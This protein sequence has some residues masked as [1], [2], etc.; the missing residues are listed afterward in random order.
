MLTSWR[1]KRLLVLFA[2][3]AHSAIAHAEP[4]AYGYAPYKLVGAMP[5]SGQVLLWSE[6][7]EEYVIAREGEELDDWRVDKID[8]TA[9]GNPRVVLSNDG[10]VDVL[11]LVR[12]PSPTALVLLQPRRAPTPPPPAAPPP[13]RARGEEIVDLTEGPV[14]VS[15]PPKAQVVVTRGKRR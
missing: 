13:P 9:L 12:L 1:M 15:S 4:S 11:S 10:L 7:D 3:V 8:D 2:F 5:E 14:L 6:G